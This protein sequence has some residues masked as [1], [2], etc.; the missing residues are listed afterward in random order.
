M[1]RKAR[2]I[3]LT[4]DELRTL[5]ALAGSGSTPARMWTRA[6]VLLLLHGGRTHDEVV[7]ALDVA[8]RTIYS[9]KRRYLSGGLA[10][11]LYDQPR[12]GRPARNSG[13]AR[14]GVAPPARLLV[15][16]D[17]PDLLLLLATYFELSG[18]EVETATSAADA[19]EAARRTH[20]DAVVSDVGMPEMSGH[21]L[22]A[23]LRSMPAYRGVPLVAVTGFD[24]YDDAGR[25]RR[26]G[27]DAHL[28]K[29]LDPAQL[30]GVVRGLLAGA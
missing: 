18:Y 26:A 17:A 16:D 25:S 27:F 3:S 29:P 6:Q 22:A 4:A 10:A 19:L 28:K 13:E 20:F 30:V 11:A 12:P 7:E 5:T 2:P 21:E 8:V 24:Q 9:I 15:V 14:A 1:P 23:A